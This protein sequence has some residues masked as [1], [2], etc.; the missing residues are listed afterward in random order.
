M[1]ASLIYK[2]NCITTLAGGLL[3]LVSA[4][5]KMINRRRT[6]VSIGTHDYDTLKGP[7]SYEARK[8]EEI[9]FISLGNTKTLNGAELM[10][11]LAVCVCSSF[12]LRTAV[13]FSFTLER[14]PQV[15]LADYRG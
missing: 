13:K 10:A 6:L 8:P 4:S 7:F 12:A 9:K 14:T 15:F 11:D 1:I 5:S 3:L 2:T